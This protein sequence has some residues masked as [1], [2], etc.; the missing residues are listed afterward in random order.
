METRNSKGPIADAAELS[1]VLRETAGSA[2]PDKRQYRPDQVPFL[3]DTYSWAD[4][5]S[6]LELLSNLLTLRLK[7][8]HAELAHVRTVC[9]TRDYPSN[10]AFQDDASRE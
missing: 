6:E 7:A 2:K 1:D 10:I 4:R 8:V 3:D 5:Q 9:Q